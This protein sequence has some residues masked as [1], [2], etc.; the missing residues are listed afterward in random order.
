MRTNDYFQFQIDRAGV[1]ELKFKVPEGLSL[2]AV[3]CD[4]MKQFDLSADKQTLTLSLREKT[5]GELG[6]QIVAVKNAEFAKLAEEQQLP[7]IEPLGV[8]LEAGQILIYASEA[9]DVITDA[10][11]I[12]AARPDPNPPAASFP[13][14]RLVSAWTFNRRW[15]SAR[16]WCES[17]RG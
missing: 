2:E 4:R 12:V 11:K 9:I 7:T 1:F 17:P 10:A 6:V 8:E 14:A 3:N 5:L 13:N 15:R 16:G